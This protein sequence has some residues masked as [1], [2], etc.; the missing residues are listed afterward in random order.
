MIA[1]A[2]NQGHIQTYAEM[3]LNKSYP[4]RH[5]KPVFE[6]PKLYFERGKKNSMTS[7]N[8]SSSKQI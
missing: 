4:G 8:D 5:L 3:D 7:E 1:V 6:Y 2:R